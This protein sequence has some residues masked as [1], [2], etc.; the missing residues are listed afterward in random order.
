MS[1]P[2]SHAFWPVIHEKTIFEDLSKCSLFCHLLG[3]KRGQPLYVNIFQLLSFKHVSYQVWS[4]LAK[5]FLRSD[6]KGKNYTGWTTDAASYHKLSEGLR[7]FQIY[8][9]RIEVLDFGASDNRYYVTES[10][11]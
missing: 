7:S 9:S 3:P 8:A 4:K 2:K 11:K 1:L 5:W 6:L 10:L